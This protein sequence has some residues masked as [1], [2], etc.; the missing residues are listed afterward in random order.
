[1]KTNTLL[2]NAASF[3]SIAFM[4]VSM[5]SSVVAQTYTTKTNGAWSS[6]STWVG[7]SIPK[8]SNIPGSAIINIKHSISY[9][10]S[11]IVNNGIVNIYNESGVTPRIE[12]ANGVNIT[13]KAT[14]KIFITGGIMQ[15]YRF[16]G[17]GGSG[18]NQSGSF[19]NDGGYFQSNSSYVEIAQNWTNQATGIVVFNNSSVVIGKEYEVKGSAKDTL[20]YTSVSVGSQGSGNFKEQGLGVYFQSFRAEVASTDGD[21]T[22]GENVV[23]NGLIDYIALKNSFTGATGNGEIIFAENM[24]TTGIKL[25]AYC[26]SAS[27]HYLPNGLVRGTQTADCSLNYF[28]ATLNGA[29]GAAKM[30]FS[31]NPVLIAGTDKQAGAK[32]LYK[33]VYPG[34]DVLLNIDSIV[35]GA[36]LNVVDDNTGS[37]GGFREAF[38]PQITSGSGKGKSYVVFAF[39][40]NITATTAPYALDTFSLTALDIDGGSNLY[41]FDEISAGAGS[42]AKYTVANPSISLTEV[43]PGSFMGINMDGVSQNGIDTSFKRTMFTASNSNV[44]SF[45]VK[46]GIVTTTSQKTLRLFSLYSQGFNY[47]NFSILPVKLISFNASLKDANVDLKWST[48]NQENLSHF[49][50][51]RSTDGRNFNDVG[52]ILSIANSS[53]TLNYT[54]K[55]DIASV[56]SNM[57]YYRLCTVDID[58]RTE[59]SDVRIIRLEKQTT[60]NIAVVTYPNPVTSEL[61]VTIPTEWQ[62]KKVSYELINVKGQLSMKSV[63]NTSSQ[64]QSLNVSNI[65]SGMYIMKVTCDRQSAQQKIIKF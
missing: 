7:G 47:Q 31:L 8:A 19:T 4:L 24:S 26:A 46:L 40:F 23:A 64:T 49:T 6:A 28:P 37:N 12:I 25:Q 60:R 45:T 14:G 50:V 20:S 62:N 35:G 32:Y 33:G 9:S 52:M 41:E 61:L 63:N 48:A 43:L 51:Q 54:M 21:F 22:I 10:G 2:S 65:T 11:D 57:V 34:I 5:N 15:Q 58:G 55:D 44:S 13:N 30:N 38:Q 59:Y 56:N 53:Q 3:F 1:M 18:T 36:V 42:T 27:S 17:G 16:A 39:N 29:T